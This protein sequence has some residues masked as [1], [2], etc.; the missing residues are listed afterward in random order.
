MARLHKVAKVSIPF[1]RESISKALSKQGKRLIKRSFN[2]LQTGKHIQSSVKAKHDAAN[3]R[4]SIPFKR[5]S[6]SKGIHLGDD[7]FG[8]RHMFQF[9]SNGKAYPKG[10]QRDSHS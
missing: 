4:V 9:P 8:F 7:R 1:K 6:I 3:A 2:S 5:E 10:T